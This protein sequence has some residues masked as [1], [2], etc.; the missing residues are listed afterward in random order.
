M[1]TYKIQIGSVVLKGGPTVISTASSSG[2]S[3]LLWVNTTGNPGM[4][5]AGMGDTLSGILVSLLGQGLSSP[6]AARAGVFLHG[7]AGDSLL[8]QEGYGLQ[9][10]EV[11][12]RVGRVMWELTRHLERKPPGSVKA[13]CT[14]LEP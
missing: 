3:L 1:E 6:D 10:S 13:I 7:L 2:K 8:E 14:T 9:A 5:S 12:A 11:A 4:A